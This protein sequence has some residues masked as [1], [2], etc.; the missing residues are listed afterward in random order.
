MEVARYLGYDAE[1]QQG[2]ETTWALQWPEGGIF[3]GGGAQ[4]RKD[5][6]IAMVTLVRQCELAQDYSYFLKMR[7]EITAWLKPSTD[8]AS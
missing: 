5:T 1:A 2:V 7:P 6:G 4:H 3:A 8:T